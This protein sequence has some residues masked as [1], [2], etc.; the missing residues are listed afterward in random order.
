M[1]IPQEEIE[2]SHNSFKAANKTTPK[3]EV[4]SVKAKFLI[5][6]FRLFL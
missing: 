5:T 4:L 2:L 6:V 1:K 3:A